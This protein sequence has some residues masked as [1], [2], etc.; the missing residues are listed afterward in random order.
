MQTKGDEECLSA[1]GSPAVCVGDARITQSFGPPC[2]PW[3][4]GTCGATPL[5]SLT[6]SLRQ[7]PRV[8]PRASHTW[9]P[10]SFGCARHTLR[11]ILLR[12]RAP[13]QSGGGV[14]SLGLHA[15]RLARPI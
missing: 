1:Y 5:R 8:P 11:N 12:T 4:R 10:E 9:H 2:A 14:G 6:H 13:V 3:V 7:G 15:A